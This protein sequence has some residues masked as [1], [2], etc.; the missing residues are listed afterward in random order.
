MVAA[1][2]SQAIKTVKRKIWEHKA[3][4]QEFMAVVRK[5]L[6]DL[7][8]FLQQFKAC[9]EVFQFYYEYQSWFEE[10]HLSQQVQKSVVEI[11][12]YV[13]VPDTS[14]VFSVPGLKRRIM[15]LLKN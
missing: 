13:V 3:V 9:R 1:R 12:R 6:R 14:M 4:V 15:G 11:E 7:S 2:L 8:Y 10:L 5:S